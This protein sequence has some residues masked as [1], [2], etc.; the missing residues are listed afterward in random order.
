MIKLFS[1]N[2]TRIRRFSILAQDKTQFRRVTVLIFRVRNTSASAHTNYLV[3]FLKSVEPLLN[4][5]RVF[6]IESRPCQPL[7][8]SVF[9]LFQTRQK[10][11][12]LLLQ[13]RRAFY[14]E[15]PL[16]N[17]FLKKSEIVFLQRFQAVTSRTRPCL[18][19]LSLRSGAH[20]TALRETVN[21]QF[22]FIFPDFGFHLFDCSN[23]TQSG[24]LITCFS[25]F[26]RFSAEPG[27]AS[28]TSTL[29]WQANRPPPIHKSPS[30]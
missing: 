15:L 5:G 21:D 6:Y 23:A 8:F 4:Q 9:K 14:T 1:L 11:S 16:V 28:R 22:R 24:Q 18:S 26:W 25:P 2:H 20:S 29:L 19:G 27:N 12:G 30:R 7:I 13:T 17:R 10:P 3:N